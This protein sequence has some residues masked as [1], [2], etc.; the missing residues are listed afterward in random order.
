MYLM[1]WLAFMNAGCID[2]E[3]HMPMMYTKFL[4]IF[5]LPICYK[6]TAPSKMTMILEDRAASWIVS[7][8]VCVCFSV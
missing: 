5:K 2:W 7:T 3:E 4:K 1:T 8:L 6:K